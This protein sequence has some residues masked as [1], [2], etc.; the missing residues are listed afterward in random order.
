MNYTFAA[1]SLTGRVRRNNEDNF[2]LDTEILPQDHGDSPLICRSV[3]GGRPCLAGVFDGMGGCSHGEYASFLAASR[4]RSGLAQ[5]GKDPAQ[6]LTDLCMQANEDVCSAADGS[7]MGTTCAL[8][9]LQN[10]RYTM[11]SIG[12]SPIFLFREGRLRQLSVDHTQK[13]TYEKTSGKKALPGQKFKLTQCIGIPRE[14]MTIEPWVLSGKAQPGDCF[15]LCSDGLTDMLSQEQIRSVLAAQKEPERILPALMEKAL[16]AGGRDNITII[17][18]KAG[19]SPGP[20]RR[21][22]GSLF[23]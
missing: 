12:D 2:C 14:E 21:F 8:L 1:Q 15:L 3:S 23:R 22:L 6:R 20:L 13:A 7:P 10:R 4:F 5:L 18:A 17:C 11:C 19:V 9:C 16:D